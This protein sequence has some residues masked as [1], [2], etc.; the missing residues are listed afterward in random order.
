MSKP[1]EISEKFEP[2]FDLLD[3]EQH[4]QV[5]KVILT[6]G[7]ASSKSFNAALMVLI[8]TVEKSWKTLYSRF[9][10][11]SIGDSIKS[12]VSDKIPLL[13]YEDKLIDNKYSIDSKD[14]RGYISFKGIKTSSN[15]QT[16]NLKSL[17]GFN[18]FV[19][20]EAEEIPS[21]E[22]FKKV[23]YSIRSVDR[24]NLSVLI[25]N[26]TTKEHWIYKELFEANDIP[27]GFCG[28]KDNIMYIH[29]SYLDVNPDY[30]PTNIKLD[31]EK[32]KQKN[33]E[34]YDN[35]VLGGWITDVEG[36]LIPL[37]K[38]S[39]APIPND[40]EYTIT[41]I[42]ISDPADG[43]GD[44]LST[45]FLKLVYND[46][47]L[48]VYVQDVVHSALGIESNTQRIMDRIR[49]YKTERIVVEGNGVG[50]A[51]LYQLRTLND[52]KCIIEGFHERMPKDAKINAFH[53]FVLDHFIFDE[54]YRDNPDY[55]LF[56]SDLV[57]YRRD[58]GTENNHRKDAIDVCASASKYIKVKY[59][60]MLYNSSI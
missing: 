17:T 52:T 19:V 12:E 38:M 16:A 11:T 2:F 5:D 20:D 28:V 41:N 6:G 56:V 31:Y 22:T 32:L 55:K 3:D 59:K 8:G 46:N 45:I 35:I 29:S 25:L 60:N 30:I 44:K 51:L 26:P 14:G 57:A 10:N 37:S 39:L 47:Q 23:F 13:N 24:R 42:A 7:R 33:P 15:G 27:D 43:G 49:K 54:K 48:T 50:V 21:Y 1:I 4:K 53:E 34:K 18:C 40:D 9:T 58:G 36:A